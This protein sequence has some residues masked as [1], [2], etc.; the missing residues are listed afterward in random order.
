MIPKFLAKQNQQ[1]QLEALLK[2]LPELKGELHLAEYQK[3]HKANLFERIDEQYQAL[4]AM[5]LMP[6]STFDPFYCDIE[7]PI[8]ALQEYKFAEEIYHNDDM[9]HCQVQLLNHDQTYGLENILDQI[10]RHQDWNL[11]FRMLKQ[12][13][14]SWLLNFSEKLKN[15]K[16]HHTICQI[17]LLDLINERDCLIAIVQ[18]ADSWYW[19]YENKH[20]I[21]G[22]LKKIEVLLKHDCCDELNKEIE[23][24]ILHRVKAKLAPLMIVK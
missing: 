22:V 16:N 7:Q 18:N 15:N 17:E 4:K 19:S 8:E 3:T 6:D 9:G 21:P 23:L 13:P 1:N 20:M 24:N 10:D 14:L 2:L 11:C 5:K 12:Q